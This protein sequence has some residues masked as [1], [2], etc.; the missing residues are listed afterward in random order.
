[1]TFA[2]TCGATA[3]VT[4]L[5]VADWGEQ[6]PHVVE[7]GADHQLRVLARPVQQQYTV[8]SIYPTP[9]LN[10]IYII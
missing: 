3:L 8:Y 4:Y 6:L 10:S 5:P 1:M 2:M 7:E 9:Y